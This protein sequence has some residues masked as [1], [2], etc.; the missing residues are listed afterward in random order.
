MELPIS[1]VGNEGKKGRRR[2]S[3]LKEGNVKVMDGDGGKEL[4]EK[5]VGEDE[6]KIGKSL[7]AAI[8]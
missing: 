8:E 1:N 2:I 5:E 7:F 4:Q 3:S 6:V